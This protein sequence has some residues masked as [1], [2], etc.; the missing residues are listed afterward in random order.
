MD[1]STESH[2][3]SGAKS[4]NGLVLRWVKGENGTSD[5]ALSDLLARVAFEDEGILGKM[6]RQQGPCKA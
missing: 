4:K 1:T 2:F 5:S 3:E 6:E